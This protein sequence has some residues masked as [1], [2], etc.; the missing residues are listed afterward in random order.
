MLVNV[1]PLK[2]ERSKQFNRR[3]KPSYDRARAIFVLTDGNPLSA[4]ADMQ[5]F[6]EDIFFDIGQY[7]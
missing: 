2:S 4:D 7:A 5:N 3:V 1:N 6:M